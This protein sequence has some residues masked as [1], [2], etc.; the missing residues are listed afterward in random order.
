[1]FFITTAF[2]K[3][4]ELKVLENVYEP[5][6]DSFLLAKNVIIKPGSQV[7]DLGTGTGIQGINA[8]ILGATKV[9]STDVNEKALENAKENAETLGFLEKIEFRP[10]NL[11]ECMNKGE[12]FDV[13]IFNPPYVVS[14]EKKFVELDG[15]KKGREIL[16][17]FL[18]EVGTFLK[19]DGP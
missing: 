8:A 7:L 5:S 18:E 11:F 10:G 19:K 17:K 15:G 1:M 14:D 9:V 16:D 6:E 4:K 2:F 3:D 13:I 12:K